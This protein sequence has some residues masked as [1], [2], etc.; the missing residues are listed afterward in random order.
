VPIRSAG[1]AQLTVTASRTL[2]LQF[3][4]ILT[5]GTSPTISSTATAQVGNLLFSPAIA[6]LDQSGCGGVGGAAISLSGFGQLNVTGD[7]VSDGAISVSGGSAAIAGDAYTRC[8]A[9]VPGVSLVCYPSGATPACTYPDVAGAFRTGYHYSD[10]GY[11]VPGPLGG[12]QASPGTNVLML[13]GVYSAP[14]SLG[15]GRCY[16]L[17]GGVYSFQAGF[18][19]AGTLVSNELKPPDEPVPGNN[20]ALASPQFWNSTGAH[21]AGSVQYQAVQCTGNGN[22][23]TGNC[24]QGVGQGNGCTAAPPGTWAFEVTSTRTDTYNGNTYPRESAPS[25]CQTVIVGNHQAIQVS[26][27]NV[28]GATAYNVYA[29]PPGSGCAGPFGL[30]ESLPV[31]GSVLNNGLAGCPAFTGS[32]CSL[33]FETIVINGNDI[34]SP[35]GPNVGA[36]PGSLGAYPPNSE[37]SPLRLG[38]P[39][40]NPARLA[41]AAGDRANENNCENIAGV[42]ASCPAAVTPG[43]VVLYLPGSSCL[44]T[45]NASDTYLFSGYQFNWMALY[46]APSNGCAN[47]LGG[48]LNTA[49]IGLA[50]TPGASVSF[51]SD[52]TFDSPATGGVI[53]RTVS[54]TGDEP[55]ITFSSAYAPVPFASRL[56]S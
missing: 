20:A 53:A 15:T 18:A 47:V 7:I 54:F 45:T 32:T 42:Y 48:N 21:C 1:G 16:F 25:T 5:N 26:V 28:P 23:G 39:N 40:Q 33:G 35:F 37:T 51:A 6:A 17:A 41:G 19:N 52:D 38:R 4:R 2:S 8:Q 27:S 55:T 9:T 56:V 14:A 22:C 3:A 49:L 43:A 31:S 44:S 36:A 12:G 46:E 13:P 11:P 34:G 50:Y 24:G 30:A 10:P 29:A